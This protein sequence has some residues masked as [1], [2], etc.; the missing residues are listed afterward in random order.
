MRVVYQGPGVAREVGGLGFGKLIC[1]SELRYIIE[2]RYKNF[3]VE[4]EEVFKLRNKYLTLK[5]SGTV[6]Q[7]RHRH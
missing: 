1:L 4:K 3:D 6:L 7:V 2:E 5:G